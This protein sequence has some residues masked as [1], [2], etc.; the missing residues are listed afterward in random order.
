MKI[1][2]VSDCHIE[3]FEQSPSQLEQRSFQIKNNLKDADVILLAGDMHVGA[4]RLLNWIRTYF[5]NRPVCFVTGNH[6]YYG[7]VK[8]QVDEEIHRY[9]ENFLPDTPIKF[10]NRDT[11]YYEQAD[12]T[13]VRVIGATLWSDFDIF[14]PEYKQ[15]QIENA[16]N[17]LADYKRIRRDTGALL[18][19]NDTIGWFHE[20][21][22]YIKQQLSLPFDGKT[23]VMTHHSPSDKCSTLAYLVRRQWTD[24]I[25]GAF[26]SNLEGFIAEHDIDLW[27]SGHT[28][29][30]TDTVIHGTR[31][32]SSQ[33]G[34]PRELYGL[35]NTKGPGVVVEV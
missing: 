3:F 30:D 18:T 33:G 2:I 17:G 28:H 7:D 16:Q 15:Y 25:T 32:I 5:P 29:Y 23:I 12:G 11:E 14:G 19:P 8:E 10:L 27:V 1:G 9:L 26:V 34:Y 4:S 20:D 6:E 13:K 24:G 21:L 35:G 22:A 31:L